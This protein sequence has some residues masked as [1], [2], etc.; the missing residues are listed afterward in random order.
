MTQ[1]NECLD[2]E[3]WRKTIDP[4][5]EISNMGRVRS[6]SRQ[7]TGLDGVKRY[8]H[9]R[10]LALAKTRN[11]TLQVYI[12]KKN[13]LVHNVVAAAFLDGH[14]PHLR[15]KHKNGDKTDNRVENLILCNSKQKYPPKSQVI[16]E[17]K[18]TAVVSL[19]EKESLFQ[20][21][22][23]HLLLLER[24]GLT[25]RAQTFASTMLLKSK[26][27]IEIEELVKIINRLAVQNKLR[28]SLSALNSPDEHRLCLTVYEDSIYA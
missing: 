21:N 11:G 14:Q 12:G 17:S 26:N 20:E 19:T 24:Q 4:N 8:L 22:I 5:Y 16:N 2:G 3:I 28:C 15:V 25:R 1:R 13:C 10:I 27:V 6:R 9:G 23:K 18:E 7:V